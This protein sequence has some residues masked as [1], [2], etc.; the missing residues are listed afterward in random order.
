MRVGWNWS[1]NLPQIVSICKTIC[2]EFHALSYSNRFTI[3]YKFISHA[4]VMIGLTSKMLIRINESWRSY[5]SESCNSHQLLFLFEVRFTAE[6]EIMRLDCSKAVTS[7]QQFSTTKYVLL[8]VSCVNKVWDKY[9]SF[10][11]YLPYVHHVGFTVSTLRN[12]Q[13]SV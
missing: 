11:F 8:Q 10:Y 3:N 9:C 1:W 7:Q 5:V 13:F 6:L 2:L 4:T 12:S